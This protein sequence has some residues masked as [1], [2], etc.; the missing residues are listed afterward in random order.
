MENEMNYFAA[1]GFALIGWF[2]QCTR[3]Y[4]VWDT[5]KRFNW[6]KFWRHYD[7]YIILGFVGA[8]ALAFVGDLV[9]T[10]I[11]SGW[12]DMEGTPYDERVNIFL[13]LLVI[14]FFNKWKKF[15]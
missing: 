12:L 11:L 3:F 2:V 13:G 1:V 4:F 5:D 10:Y 6:K 15:E 7:K 9:W 14:P 8:I